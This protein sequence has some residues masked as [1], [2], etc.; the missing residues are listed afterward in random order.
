MLHWVLF[1]AFS[2]WVFK[3]DLLSLPKVLLRHLPS[4]GPLSAAVHKNM[5]WITGIFVKLASFM[6][7]K[8]IK[9]IL[10]LFKIFSNFS[11]NYSFNEAVLRIIKCNV[12]F[13]FVLLVILIRKISGRLRVL[14]NLYTF[15]SFLHEYSCYKIVKDFSNTLHICT[16][17]LCTL[18]YRC[19]IIGVCTNPRYHILFVQPNLIMLETFQ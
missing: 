16:P 15:S 1:A 7:F 11:S 13:V 17:R 6:I 9:I 2:L 19:V 12:W 4:I 14:S 18:S 5:T 3:T 10:K 8:F